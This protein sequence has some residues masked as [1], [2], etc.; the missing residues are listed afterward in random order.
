MADASGAD[1]D[2][3]FGPGPSVPGELPDSLQNPDI[4]A[5]SS[6]AS[7]PGGGPG[8]GVTVCDV[9]AESFDL[10][11]PR[12]ASASSAA[13]SS[14]FFSK[15]TSRASATAAASSTMSATGTHKSPSPSVSM[16]MLIGAHSMWCS[17]FFVAAIDAAN[18]AA[19]AD[20]A[21]SARSRSFLRSS[22]SASAQIWNAGFDPTT[23]A[24]ALST[25]SGEHR[26]KLPA[27]PMHRPIVLTSAT[28]RLS[29]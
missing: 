14:D 8:T 10:F 1:E 12:V 6:P 9:A 13:P 22:A 21:A 5:A 11:D 17:F 15:S 2:A 29:S 28:P 27:P 3:S 20:S 7:A 19:A 24:F 25:L 18:S 23:S 4:R 16:T 26:S